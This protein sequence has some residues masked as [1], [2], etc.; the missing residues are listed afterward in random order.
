MLC[1]G[2]RC[3]PRCGVMMVIAQRNPS[4]ESPGPYPGLQLKMLIKDSHVETLTPRTSECDKV[5]E[6]ALFLYLW[7]IYLLI[8]LFETWSHVA[9]ARPKLNIYIKMS[10]NI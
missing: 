5:R 3:E 10:L 7:L 2:A 9:Q 1:K 8:C 4:I 6:K